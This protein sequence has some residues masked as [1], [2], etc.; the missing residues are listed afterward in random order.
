MWKHK[1]VQTNMQLPQ[2]W[3]TDHTQ[4]ETGGSYEGNFSAIAD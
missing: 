4:I 3:W 1:I 2:I